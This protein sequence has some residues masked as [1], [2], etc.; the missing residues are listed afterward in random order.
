VNKVANLK[1][2]DYDPIHFGFI[3]AA[4]EMN[5]V[6]ETKDNLNQIY[7]TGDQIAGTDLIFRDAAK[8]SALL[9]G[10]DVQPS[11]GFTVGIVG[12][13]RLGEYFNLKAVPSLA[14]GKRD[15]IYNGEMF[16]SPD[17]SFY[18]DGQIKEIKPS[19]TLS[20]TSTQKINSTFVDFPF[21]IKYKSKRYRNMR[22][23]VFGGIKFSF[24]LASQAN[25]EDNNLKTPKLYRSDTYGLIGAGLDFY[26]NWF[27]FGIE[28]N[29][30]Y[31]FRDIL[32]KEDNIYTGGIESLRSKIFMLTFTFE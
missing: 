10:I 8:D 6:I 27:K 21:Y 1:L 9:F 17:T 4:N 5:F 2:Y 32:V 7:F 3:V 31:G 14:F 26:M 18:S 23:Y 15:L 25:K 30:S 13:L 20:F 11:L 24:D 19:D 16:L 12:D 28:F 29:M 22:A